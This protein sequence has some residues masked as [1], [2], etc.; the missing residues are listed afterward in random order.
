[1]HPPVADLAI[2]S[3]HEKG[4]WQADLYH[5]ASHLRG[6]E[7]EQMGLCPDAFCTFKRGGNVEEASIWVK[8]NWPQA[9]V[10]VV[11]EIEDDEE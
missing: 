11:E 8:A 5:D 10:K 6:D 3:L 9:E 4:F 7:M 2:V 1:M